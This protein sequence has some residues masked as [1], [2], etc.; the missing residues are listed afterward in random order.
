MITTLSA[1]GPT[2]VVKIKCKVWDNEG[3]VFESDT[4]D[5]YVENDGSQNS[6]SS[7]K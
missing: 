1:K 2:S 5:V 3:S 6:I 4:L 7:I